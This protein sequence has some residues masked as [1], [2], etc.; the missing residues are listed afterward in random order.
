MLQFFKSMRCCIKKNEHKQPCSEIAKEIKTQESKAEDTN[1][2]RSGSGSSSFGD[3]QQ[4]I[5]VYEDDLEYYMEEF[6]LPRDAF[7]L[8]SSMEEKRQRE[9]EEKLEKDLQENK[10]INPRP[11][12]CH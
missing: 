6:N 5:K 8:R 9:I 3:K 7:E 10:Y 4:K 12:E 11:F 1:I 2:T